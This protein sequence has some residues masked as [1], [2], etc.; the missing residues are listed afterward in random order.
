TGSA[1]QVVT[2]HSD[3]PADAEG[4]RK[5]GRHSAHGQRLARSG[6]TDQPGRLASSDGD[7]GVVDERPVLGGDV[8]SLDRQYR[9]A[10]FGIGGLVADGGGDHDSLSSAQVVMRAP[11]VLTDNTVRTMSAAG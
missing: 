10:R 2:Q 3:V 9:R 11:M 6:L 4:L 5:Q 1:E 8:Q 7:R